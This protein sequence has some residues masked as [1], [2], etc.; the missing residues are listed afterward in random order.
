MSAN[1]LRT[2][3]ERHE[4]LAQFRSVVEGPADSFAVLFL[5]APVGIGKSTP[6]RRFADEYYSLRSWHG[7]D[8]SRPWGRRPSRTRPSRPPAV[9]DRSWPARGA[10]R[11][12]SGCALA[13]PRSADR[14][15][16]SGRPENLAARVL[17]I[18]A[19]GASAAMMIPVGDGAYA[20]G[21][22]R[23]PRGSPYPDIAQQAARA[24]LAEA[25]SAPSPG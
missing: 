10:P 16:A 20:Q 9:V 5:T 11:Q 4:E 14:D 13:R 17:G 18:I 7:R 3:V 23:S 15:P 12:R 25:R 6:L 22:S 21:L 1:R 8:R 2:F 19:A 24:E